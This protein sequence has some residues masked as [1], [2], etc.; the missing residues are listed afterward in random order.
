MSDAKFHDLVVNLPGIL[1][2]LG[3]LL[4]VIAAFLV[5]L[6][7]GRKTDAAKIETAAKID[8]VHE[9][10]KEGNALTQTGNEAVK[11]VEQQTNGVTEKLAAMTQRAV[12]A[13]TRNDDRE[14]PQG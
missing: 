7:N 4:T 9:D 8:A 5:S 14:H 1:L 13:E 6:R 12:E 3:T 2:Q 10:L 11:R